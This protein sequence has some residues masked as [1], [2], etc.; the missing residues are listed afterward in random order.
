M[1]KKK[2]T[3]GKNKDKSKTHIRIDFQEKKTVKTENDIQKKTTIK[4]QNDIQ[5]KKST[6]TQSDIEKELDIRSYSEYKIKDDDSILN[7]EDEDIETKMTRLVIIKKKGGNVLENMN[8]I[9]K[10]P[11]Q[12][13]LSLKL[14]K[15]KQALSVLEKI[16]IKRK[17]INFFQKL[18]KKRRK[19][20]VN[21]KKNI[22]NF[23]QNLKK[24][25][26]KVYLKKIFLTMIKDYPVSIN[27][28]EILNKNKSNQML[29]SPRGNKKK[30]KKFKCHNNMNF[31]AELIS[32]KSSF[33]K[34]NCIDTL[35]LKIGKEKEKEKEM[36]QFKK[37]QI[38][39]KNTIHLEINN[40]THI[41]E[42]KIKKLDSLKKKEKEYLMK[43][44]KEKKRLQN[45]I[46]LFKRK[47]NISE[48]G[49]S[50]IKQNNNLSEKDSSFFSEQYSSN[51][52]SDDF[53]IIK[54]NNDNMNN[55]TDNIN[56]KNTNEINNNKGNKGNMSVVLFSNDNSIKKS[57][58]NEDINKKDDNKKN[59]E[60]ELYSIK[61]KESKKS[62]T[63]K[64]PDW[65][66][67][68]LKS[69]HINATKLEKPENRKNMRVSAKLSDLNVKRVDISN[70]KMFNF[71]KQD[72]IVEKKIRNYIS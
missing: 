23:L 68:S 63:R 70:L 45:E 28:K 12:K 39:K 1:I 46:N 59:N 6:K 30:P 2:T 19:S 44:R 62:G 50:Q 14:P 38:E 16:E 71:K 32:K 34:Q 24:Y 67:K 5:E 54:N 22:L 13:E 15:I 49:L 52:G 60:E 72:E 51:L 53:K 26:F 25:I 21:N 10:R 36:G 35:L 56:S 33:R 69:L 65:G 7:I 8:I 43:I 18:K 20:V 4:T 66:R 42:K 17:K 61:S 27:Y 3:L 55:T 64:S 37:T 29:V 47:T 11:N 57:N 31:K 9:K 58:N 40:K 41:I 48:E